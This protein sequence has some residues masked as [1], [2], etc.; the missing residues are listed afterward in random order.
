MKKR[1]LTIF[2]FITLV[3]YL[4]TTFSWYLLYL[5]LEIKTV[6]AASHTITSRVDFDLGIQNGTDTASSEGKLS[7]KPDGVWGPRTFK[8]PNLTLGDQ[9]AIASDGNYVYVLHSSDNFFARYIPSENR[10][11]TL[12]SAPRFSYPG[13]Q[14]V[15][16]GNFIYA[17]FGGYQK[18]FARYSIVS[19]VWETR[20]NMPDL[21]YGGAACA[22]DGTN[23]FC[24]RG[25]S[26]TD[27]WKYVP[28]TDTWA[29]VSNP[30]LAMYTGATLSYYDGN[31]YA[32]R[33]GGT[34]TMY[35]YNIAAN[36][37]YTTI[38]DNITAL[39]V[40]PGTINEDKTAAIKNDEIFLTRDQGTQSFYKYKITTNTWTTLTNTPQATRYVGAVY[41][42]ADD[43]VYV[44]RGLGQYDF[45][46]YNPTT[47]AFLGPSDLPITQPPGSGSDL[48]YDGG[49]IY[50]LRG[51]NTAILYK[52]E[53][54]T[55]IWTALTSA[56]ATFND[57]TKGVQ[58]G[59]DIYFFRGS[60]T[61]AFYKYS[62][63][64]DA[65]TTLTAVTPV[66]SYYGGTLAYPGTGDFIYATRGATSRL[67]WRYQIST[68]TWSDIAVADLPDNAEA[69]YGA[70]MT[71][72][73]TDIYY[74]SGYGISSLL[75]Y[76]I[77]TNTW[78]VINSLPFAPNWGTDM[79]YYNGKIFFQAGFYKNDFWEYTIATNTWRRLPYLQGTYYYDIG[80]Y[81]G[82]SLTIDSTNGTIYS[83]SG[84]GLIWL[85]QYTPSSYNYIASGVWTSNAIDTTYMQSFTS[86]ST[87]VTTPGDSSVAFETRT[88]T[89]SASWNGWQA[90]SGSTIASPPARFVQ[91]RATLTATTDRSQTPTINSVQINYV[92]DEVSPTNP[93]TFSG[94]SQAAGGVAISSGQSYKY[95]A[96]YFTW[97]AGTDSQTTISGYYVYFGT[98]ILADP[99]TAGVFKTDRNYLVTIPL[100]K[101]QTYYLRLQTKDTSGN[102]STATTGFVYT[103]SGVSPPI[104]VTKTSTS[105][106]S[107]GT[108]TNTST[109]SDKISLSSK[110]GFWQQERLTMP[111]AGIYYGSDLAYVSSSNKMY[112]NR[113][114]GS[115][116]FY[117]YDLTTDIW[118]TKATL[119]NTVYYGDNTVE[120]PTGYLYGTRGWNTSTF[121]SYDIVANTW[122]DAAA[123]DAPQP[124]NYGG[125][126]VYDGGIYIYALKGNNDDTFMRYNTQADNWE[127]LANIDFGA[128]DRQVNN[129]V[130]DGADLAI[131]QTNNVI[132]ATEGNTRSGFASYDPTSNSWTQLPNLPSLP[133]TGSKIEYD[134]TT[135]AIYFLAGWN[136]TLFFKYDIA[137]Q[138]WS[139]L[140]DAP[141]AISAGSTLRNV[142]GTLYVIRGGGGNQFY[143]YNIAKRSWMI[144]NV[145]L[146]G[147]WFRGNDVRTYGYGADIIKGDGNNYYLTRG[148]FDNLFTRYNP[149]TG[150]ATKLADAP[151]G[152]QSGGKLVYDSTNNKIYATTSV[153]YR[154]LFV[155]DI[156]TDSWS[157]EVNDPPPFDPDYG[158]G[159]TYDGS[160]YIY[161]TQGQT[162]QRFYRFDTQGVAG[163]KWGVLANTPGSMQYGSDIVKKGDYIYALRGQNTVGF[164]RY[165]PLSGTPVWSDPLVA[166]L[167]TG[168]LIYNDGF[169]VDGGGDLLY[170]CRGG[171]QVGCYSYSVAG[172]SWSAIANAP[173]Q[174]YTGGS[175]APVGAEKILVIAGGGT[176]TFSNGLYSY[177]MQTS[178]TSFQESGS[179]ISGTID[180]TAVYKFAGL[181]LSYTSASN[182]NIVVSTRTSTDNSTWD[183][184]QLASDEKIVG[185]NRTYKIGSATKRYMQVKLE[186]TSA[187]GIYSPTIDDY[188]IS[189]YQ[190]IDEPANPS[191]LS[192]YT[193]A[194]KSATLT[195]GNWYNYSSPLFEWPA[196]DA[197]NGATDGT[198]GTG[199]AGYYVYFGASESADIVTDGEYQTATS[200]TPSSLTAGQTYY[201]RL[202]TKDNAGNISSTEY[203]AFVYKFNDQKP[204]NP[205]T[206]TVDPPGPTNVNSYTFAWSGGTPDVS[207]CYK[208]GAIGAVE[209]CT[210]NMSVASISAYQEGNNTFY[211]RAKDVA[212][213]YATAYKTVTYQLIETAPST[214][215]NLTVTPDHSVT[216]E[217]AFTWSPPAY[218]GGTQGGLK[219]YYSINS[220]PTPGNVTLAGSQTYLPSNFYASQVDKNTIYI[221]TKDE[222]GNISYNS[223]A[224]VDFY[225]DTSAPGIPVE[226]DIADVSVKETSKWRL[227]LSWDVPTS[228]GSAGVSYYEVYRS[229]TANASCTTNEADF[230]SVASTSQTSYVDVNLTQV[231]NYYCVKAC[232]VTN[233]C[234]AVSSTIG[235]LPDG[236]WRV[237][238][239]LV[240]SQSATVKTKSAIIEWSTSRK[241][242][243]F[244]KYGKKSGTYDNEAGSSNQVTFH[245]IPLNSLD[246][247]TTYYYQTVWTDEDGNT[248]ESEE[249]SFATNPAPFVSSVKFSRVNINSAQV[250]FTIK[251]AIKASVEYGKTISYGSV[252]TISTSKSETTYSVEVSNLTEGSIYHLRL[253]GED[254]E[255][256]IY[257]SD[258]YTFETLPT[259]KIIGLRVQQVVGMPTATLRLIWTTN[260]LAST[261]VTYYPTKA[262]ATA[263]DN[264][265][266]VLKKGHEVILKNLL[267]D[268]DY[269]IL[270][271]GKDSVGNEVKTE[272][273]SLKT[274]NDVRPPDIQNLNVESTI[275]GVGENASAQ[276]VVTWDTDEQGT[277]QVEYGQGT[278]TSYNQT[279]QEDTS[280]TLNHTVTITGLSPSKIYHLRALTKDKAGNVGQSL[281]T[282]II[283]PKSTKDALN[284]VID[285]LSKT[286]GFLKSFSK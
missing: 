242:N 261:I 221:V 138:T 136:T 162:T 271:K 246:P 179:Y 43:Y 127:T 146:F 198:N 135:N 8:T 188:S 235:L 18:E 185:T 105:D 37:W 132:Y 46:K 277:T 68:D 148:N 274:A 113:G 84:Q 252:E 69:G 22:T 27:F 202:K 70:R 155:Y 238:P 82:G 223:Y 117:E 197:A 64:G 137:T 44:F 180:L 195:T 285:N 60:N 6:S 144:P 157:E 257:Y 47:N 62:I 159:M 116:T 204:D 249:L 67:F 48:F 49:F 89:D 211:L 125:S 173:A 149:T 79:R 97:T 286:F 276:I 92:G 224:S 101:G 90:V 154:K 25:A 273:R 95:T 10:W 133:A 99:E 120:G 178:S 56:P 103:Y 3:I 152:F 196:E 256:N 143:K 38:T 232:N 78:T 229:T 72:D 54:A 260:T 194:T 227:A 264:I 174:I 23:L 86:L 171:N 50:Y 9:A 106:F 58:V 234:S 73:G 129:L 24:L 182:T 110:A 228:S 161:W 189:Y 134:A 217:F 31:M 219:Y 122:S 41:N 55:G 209:Q 15:V 215:Q 190:D 166:D 130:G 213:N 177:I 168:A 128:P 40:A 7:L 236:K 114:Y 191:L 181:Q 94:V 201:L 237:A 244:V 158:V 206:M 12:A 226:V 61:T 53:I 239:E 255:A 184:W 98:D 230:V 29:G 279:T 259:P 193:T 225:A 126:L 263:L 20:A 233:Q 17:Q 222:I 203:S 57:D 109:T 164:Y 145:G 26:T 151:A 77:G 272:T 186:V 258:D 21:T 66:S 63:P 282:V 33:G 91:V 167:P 150:E 278:G 5:P 19:D 87:S 275:V 13:A 210:S 36:V 4:F 176:N 118:T 11:K 108:A 139:S 1:K 254:D 96:P 262:P 247:G 216:G 93:G 153:Y 284:L 85:N 102:I 156:T 187:D 269:T 253:A 267:D 34:T 220:L 30:A 45:W 280:K 205:T 250:T 172:N 170:A 248:G 123:A 107:D 160:R 251:S 28:A 88:S 65:W 241:S 76:T 111:P 243:S 240:A 199:I 59:T 192:A 115:N 175:G 212:G 14:L 112:L 266:L 200:Y 75:K 141:L 42:A 163:A 245:S 104:T 80:P 207:Y 268:M 35:R 2:R 131:D 121:W 140:P 16:I 281:D 51:A 124:I 265:S 74:S 83:T 32:M 208:T 270:I 100:T 169:L 142:N 165:G 119:P 71:S 52:Y 183:D 39:A 214:V 218:F 231:K 147:G 81:N 283:T